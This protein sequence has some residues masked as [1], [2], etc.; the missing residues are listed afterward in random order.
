MGKPKM[1]HYF[2]NGKMTISIL[3]KCFCLFVVFA[4]MVGGSADEKAN[5]CNIKFSKLRYFNFFQRLL[6][7]LRENVVR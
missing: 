5:Y 6:D 3:L 1:S 7:T 4:N 2:R